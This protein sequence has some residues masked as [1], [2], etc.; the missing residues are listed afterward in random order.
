ML[1]APQTISDFTGELKEAVLLKCYCEYKIRLLFVILMVA[2]K[3][4]KRV[5]KTQIYSVLMFF[6]FTWNRNWSMNLKTSDSCQVFYQS[7]IWYCTCLILTKYLYFN[8]AMN[9]NE[10][11]HH[12]CVFITVSET[13]GLTQTDERSRQLLQLSWVGGKRGQSRK[14]SFNWLSRS[15]S[16]GR[17]ILSIINVTFHIMHW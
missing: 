3:P 1:W 7:C 11:F 14:Q 6:F 4:T 8:W 12:C 13:A 15:S 2:C 16:A 17:V 5:C 10:F 9:L